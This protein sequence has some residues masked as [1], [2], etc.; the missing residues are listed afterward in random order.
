MIK[1]RLPYDLR[2]KKE[3]VDLNANLAHRGTSK[4]LTEPKRQEVHPPKWEE[5]FLNSL[6][7]EIFARF[8]CKRV[9]NA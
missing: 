8:L 6:R 2:L 5:T 4:H 7:K 1:K 3:G 9:S